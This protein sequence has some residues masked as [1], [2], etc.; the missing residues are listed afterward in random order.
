MKG[1]M[2]LQAYETEKFFGVNT[3]GVSTEL[4]L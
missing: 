4:F 2:R 3:L 1:E